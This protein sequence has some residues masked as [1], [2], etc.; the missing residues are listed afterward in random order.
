LALIQRTM[1]R[2][3]KLEQVKPKKNMG[4]I[5]LHAFVPI[6]IITL[7]FGLSYETVGYIV[8]LNK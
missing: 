1:H 7:D 2:D 3:V 6:L 8:Q 5:G 4:M